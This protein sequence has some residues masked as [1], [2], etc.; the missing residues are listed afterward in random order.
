MPAVKEQGTQGTVW[1]KGI[2]DNAKALFEK[3]Y[4]LLDGDV[5]DEGMSWSECFAAEGELEA[6]G[7]VFKGRPGIMPLCSNPGT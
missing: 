4:R 7:Q 3:F 1:P 2:S 5:R 6:F